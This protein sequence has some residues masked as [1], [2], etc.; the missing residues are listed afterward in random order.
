[1]YKVITRGNNV[2]GIL[3]SYISVIGSHLFLDELDHVP[4]T[5]SHAAPPNMRL[6]VSDDGGI[7]TKKMMLTR[8]LV[9]IS[10]LSV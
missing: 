1:V 4:N 3:R 8:A 2:G 5:P 9:V 10:S 6:A 7:P